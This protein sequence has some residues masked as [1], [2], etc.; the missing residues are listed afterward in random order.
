MTWTERNYYYHVEVDGVRLNY[1]GDVTQSEDLGSVC[2][3]LEF[4]LGDQPA[5]RPAYDDDVIVHQVDLSTDTENA[6][7]QFAG[8][9]SEFDGESSPYSLIIRC[10]GVL[11]ALNVARI[12]T[13]LNLTGMTDGEAVQAVLTA[14]GVTF[15]PADIGDFGYVLG[16]QVPVYWKI[17]QT[18]ADIIGAIDDPFGMKTL[19]VGNGR[20]VRFRYD[21]AP[22]MADAYRTFTKGTDA[23]VRKVHRTFGNRA[24]QQSSW[25]VQGASYTCDENCNCQPW[26]EAVGSNPRKRS[27]V[28]ASDAP[29]YQSDIIQDE[30]FA[31]WVVERLMRWYNRTP[32]AVQVT[33]ANDVSIHPGTVIGI[34]DDTYS[35]NVSTLTAYTVTTVA[36]RGDEMTLTCVGGAAGSTGTVTTGVNKRCNDTD[37]DVDLPNIDFG[38]IDVSFPPIE[39][40]FD[41]G[42]D[43]DFGWGDELP[44]TGGGDGVVV[45]SSDWEADTFNEGPL[46][47]GD[48]FVYGGGPGLDSYANYIG[49]YTDIMVLEMDITF[50][51][52][53][54]YD[55]GCYIIFR[56]ATGDWTLELYPNVGFPEPGNWTADAYGLGDG[57]EYFIFETIPNPVHVKAE[58]RDNAV[59]FTWGPAG[60]PDQYVWVLTGTE[61]LTEITLLA[62]TTGGPVKFENIT[63]A[64][65]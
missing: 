44:G 29:P 14:C 36:R 43:F 20:V 54:P 10:V 30:P 27:R 8:N 47:F 26:A 56:N 46:T 33:T 38:P 58:Y 18:G 64:R 50:Q 49:E 34:S 48:G 42:F 3:V 39:L 1:T 51:A 37:F 22:D 4:E 25:T 40:G 21:L 60:N 41:F 57:Y 15:D 32:D 28:N 52:S 13:N 53:D 62:F 12:A 59:T 17:G 9:V 2:S 6:K 16:A 23:D 7:Y 55:D 35:I 61:T 24:L 31:Q 11:D 19:A 5:A 65:T 63:M 45:I